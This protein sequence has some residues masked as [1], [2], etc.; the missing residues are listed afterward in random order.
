MS[1]ADGGRKRT[2]GGVFFTLLKD[3]MEPATLKELYADERDKEKARR[4]AKKRKAEVAEAAGVVMTPRNSPR[5]ANSTRMDTDASMF[6][7]LEMGGA[8]R[9]RTT[10]LSSVALGHSEAWASA[11]P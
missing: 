1:T 2:A 6:T 4:A 9:A 10:E 8:K 7:G 5:R 11:L 3:H